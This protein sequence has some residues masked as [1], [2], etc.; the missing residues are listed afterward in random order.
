MYARDARARFPNLRV[1]RETR[2]PGTWNSHWRGT[3]RPTMR[4]PLFGITPERGQWR[5]SQE[6]SLA[7]AAN[8][9]RMLKELGVSA[10]EVTQEQIDAWYLKERRRGRRVDLLRLSAAGKPE[11]YV[12]PSDTRLAST[13]W[14]DLKAKGSRELARLLGPG[15]FDNPK[16]VALIPGCSSGSRARRQATSCWTFSRGRAPRPRRCWSKTPRTGETGAASWPSGPSRR[17]PIRLPGGRGTTPSLPSAAPGSPGCRSGWATGNRGASA[18]WCRQPGRLRT[19][20]PP[21]RRPRRDRALPG[22]SVD[23]RVQPARGLVGD[24]LERL[25][26]D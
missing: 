18:G 13:L 20:P 9:E 8:Y 25:V 11:H 7:A 3:D 26:G 22:D 24:L 6:R 10:E 15:I 12:P 14:T 23:G 21:G 4:Y 5:W 19:K 17:R 1:P 2:R 16:S